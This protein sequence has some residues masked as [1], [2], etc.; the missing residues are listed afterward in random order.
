MA[1]SIA[2]QFNQKLM[3]LNDKWMNFSGMIQRNF[4]DDIYPSNNI[5]SSGRRESSSSGRVI[6]KRHRSLAGS[7]AGSSCDSK[8]FDMLVLKSVDWEDNESY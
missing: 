6:S 7:R 5:N 3:N 4:Q 2:R 8:E 1:L